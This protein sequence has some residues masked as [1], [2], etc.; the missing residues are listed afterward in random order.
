VIVPDA[1]A[2]ALIFLDPAREPRVA[3][4][5]RELGTDT[6]WV[7]P[8]HWHVEVLSTIRGLCLA[9][10]LDRAVADKA[11]AAL[12]SMIVAVAETSPLL[13][14]MWELRH[15]LT[16]YDAAYVAVA[17]SREAA[18]VTSDARIQRAGVAH[19]EIRVVA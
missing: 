8:A 19:C 1:S 12:R 10:K 4:A 5:V 3:A 7:V 13:P 2:A 14:R 6:A 16:A 17:E 11:A 15:N 9:G 18:L